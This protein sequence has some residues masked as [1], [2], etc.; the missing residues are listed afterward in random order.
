VTYLLTP[1]PLVQRVAAALSAL[2]LAGPLGRLDGGD[3]H[4]QT[5]PAG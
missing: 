5:A 3:S 2:A 4:V 1:C